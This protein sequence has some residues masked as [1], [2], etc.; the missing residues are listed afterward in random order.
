[1]LY[2]RLGLTPS[3]FIL[4]LCSECGHRQQMGDPL[5]P[6][7]L[8][9]GV[10][11][12]VPVVCSPLGGGIA[13]AGNASTWNR[14]GETTEIPAFLMDDNT[15]NVYFPVLLSQ[16]PSSWG[17][18][19]PRNREIPYCFFQIPFMKTYTLL[20]AFFSYCLLA[21]KRS[22]PSL[23]TGTF[24]VQQFNTCL[25]SKLVWNL[26]S[27]LLCVLGFLFFFFF[28]SIWTKFPMLFFHLH[29]T[30]ACECWSFFLTNIDSISN[31]VLSGKIPF[32]L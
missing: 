22:L 31:I 29:I 26:T 18:Q 24:L 21:L 1:M 8:K 2:W 10:A 14:A 15:R 25:C 30:S 32:L 28:Q 20:P 19:L 23:T 9:L 4:I 27:F 7:C 6:S 16:N 13:L 5:S 17:V 11:G 3:S 12:D